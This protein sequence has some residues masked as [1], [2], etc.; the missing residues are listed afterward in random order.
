MVALWA[1]VLQRV[2]NSRLILKS[3]RFNEDS[4]RQ[5]TRQRFAAHGIDGERLI[6]QDASER[7]A[8]LESYHQIDIALDPFPYTGGTT[9]ID[10]LWRAYR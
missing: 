1:K 9:S 8:Y 5:F 4:I 7:A 3:S 2:A 6:L 10:G